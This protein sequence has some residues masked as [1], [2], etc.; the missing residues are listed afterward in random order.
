[1]FCFTRVSV[2]L[3]KKKLG[4]SGDIN[5]QR[6]DSEQLQVEATHT[7]ASVTNFKPLSFSSSRSAKNTAVEVASSTGHS[8]IIHI[9]LSFRRMLVFF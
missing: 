8:R 2:I 6:G 1:M 7:P 9:F 3:S 5:N 4:N